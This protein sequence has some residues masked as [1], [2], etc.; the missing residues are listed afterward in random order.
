MK[1]KKI[2]R[3]KKGTS[4]P[5]YTKT[6][7][8]YGFLPAADYVKGFAITKADQNKAKAEAAKESSPH[9]LEE[10]IALTRLFIEK[11]MSDLPQPIM[12]FYKS[13]IP[14]EE[15]EKLSAVKHGTFNIDIIGNQK[16]I[17]DALTIETSYV[18]SKEEY[19]NCSIMVELN[20][21]G[22]R[23]SIARL[24]RELKSFYKK[25]WSKVPANLRPLYKKD[26]FESFRTHDK[27]GIALRE[28]GPS[29]I[30][31]LSE[32]SRKHFKEVLEY[33]EGL[34]IPYRINENLLGNI[35]YGGETV[36][37]I[38]AEGK[39][40]P[41]KIVA[42]GQRYNGVARKF[43]NK[44]EVSSIGASI[45]LKR[46]LCDCGNDTTNNKD[47]THKFFFIQLGFE[48]KLKSLQVLEKLRKAKIDV[49]Q[50]IS[51]DKMTT[52]ISMAEK[53][54]IP[55]VIIMGKKE[56]MENSVVVR[57]MNTRCQNT[58]AIEELVDYA[59]KLK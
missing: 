49:Y 8:F 45:N 4:L 14:R 23:E 40:Q 19:E 54:K 25:N 55:Y 13:P 38:V 30:G 3:P 11:K 22:D 9:F 46:D 10:K 41:M 48:A 56:A 31:C 37:Q 34:D 42:E 57:N 20:S 33:I 27:K 1:M 18:I 21:L 36:F 47:K 53:M 6:A 29:P 35:S 5:T 39:K 51:K 58:I 15:K 16:S 2:S 7:S 26:L 44:K 43:W 52:Q 32:S 59:K 12:L 17:A 24:Q 28:M 50:S